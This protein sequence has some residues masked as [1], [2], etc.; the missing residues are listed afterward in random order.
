VGK[1]T[2]CLFSGFCRSVDELLALLGSYAAYIVGWR[3][4]KVGSTD[5]PETSV[6][7]YQLKLCNIPEERRY[8]TQD[9]L[10]VTWHSMYESGR[11]VSGD[12]FA[13][14]TIYVSIV[15]RH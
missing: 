12:I 14:A 8:R 9:G 15:S 13:P 11:S 10:K 2:G 1:C 7:S 5:C 3:P 4:L 6:T